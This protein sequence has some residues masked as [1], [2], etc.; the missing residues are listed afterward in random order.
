MENNI[1][2]HVLLRLFDITKDLKKP[3]QMFLLSAKLRD[4]KISSFCFSRKEQGWD[5]FTV[6]FL[7]LT[8]KIYSLCP[9]IPANM[10]VF[11]LVFYFIIYLSSK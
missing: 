3:E 9:L 10:F 7:T 11:L 4:E 2:L 5:Q 8:G 6:Y 1:D